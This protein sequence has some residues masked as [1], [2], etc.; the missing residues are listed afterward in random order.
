MDTTDVGAVVEPKDGTGLVEG[1]VL[2]QAHDVLVESSSNVV[3]LDASQPQHSVHNGKWLCAYI[4]E[5][6]RLGWVKANGDDVLGIV[7]AVLL[8]FLDGPFLREQVP[9][10]M[11][12]MHTA[13][14]QVN[15][16]L[17]IRHHDDELPGYQ[18]QPGPS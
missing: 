17:V 14:K 3:K 4:G 1:D 6:E 2:G 12:A 7:V 13:S 15:I 8:N 9:A 11:L 16:L 10:P 5:D 18:C